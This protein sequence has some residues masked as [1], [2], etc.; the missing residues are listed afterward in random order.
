MAFIKNHWIKKKS[1]QALLFGTTVFAIT[2][3]LL[4]L[5]HHSWGFLHDD[6]G[7]VWHSQIKTW[8]DLFA[9]FTENSTLYVVQASNHQPP[10]PDFFY[11]YYRPLSYVFNSLQMFFFGFSPLGY[12]LVKIA[13]HALNATILFYLF[14]FFAN[15]LSLSFIGALAFALHPINKEIGWI[16]AQI[17]TINLTFTL[18]CI[19]FLKWFIDQKNTFFF[20]TSLLCFIIS[21]FCIETSLLLPIIIIPGIYL[22][23]NEKLL[24][25]KTGSLFGLASLG[26]LIFR[27]SIY[28]TRSVTIAQFYLERINPITFLS[29]RFYDILNL[30]YDMTYIQELLPGHK[31]V[32]LIGLL[33]FVATTIALFISSTKKKHLFISLFCFIIM[34]WPAL[35][36]YYTTRYLYPA[37]PFFILFFLI[38]F[39]SSKL[40]PPKTIKNLL[41]L[42]ISLVIT[43]GSIQVILSMNAL[44]HELKIPQQALAELANHKE[45]YHKNL[46]F[47]GLPCRWFRTGI[48]QAVWM[49]GINH[50]RPIFYDQATT[51]CYE[52][53]HF[54]LDITH[55]ARNIRLS[56][57][58][59][60]DA[61]FWLT[62]NYDIGTCK[63]FGEKTKNNNYTNLMYTVKKEWEHYSPFFI[64]WDYQKNVFKII[65]HIK[66]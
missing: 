15:H 7:V 65:G 48:A 33:L 34:L 61:H 35:I 23:K 10:P 16:A 2:F 58:N 52:D 55:Q 40:S 37:L 51:V 46:C 27:A 26:Y 19:L 49:Q 43:L 29:N 63:S 1:S 57:I 5:L 22:Y 56:L 18:L 4:G 31:I 20:I 25:L 62:E 3:T 53:P 14:S 41:V 60:N 59:A 13:L 30:L 36:R 45:I 38:A 6:F 21:L 17:H 66:R 54:N 39:N 9:L 42:L 28:T 8:Q 11:V 24:W 12:F 50:D 47:I 32:K 44:Q 64:T